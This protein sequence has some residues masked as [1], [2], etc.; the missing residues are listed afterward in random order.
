M[1]A[2]GLNLSSGNAYSNLV[3]VPCQECSSRLR[4][5]T[6]G[7]GTTQSYLVAKIKGTNMCSG[8]QMPKGAPLTSTQQQTIVDW[9]AQGTP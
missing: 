3:G 1:P 8:S 2:E 6:C 4:V 7:P 9:I 5:L